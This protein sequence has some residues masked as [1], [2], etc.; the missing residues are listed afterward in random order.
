MDITVQNNYQ[1]LVKEIGQTFLEGR[2]RAAAA[3]N[4]QLVQSYW[5]IGK[6]IVEYE[7]KGNVRAEYG[8]DLIA[9]LS[10]DLTRLYGKG[11]GHSNLIYIRKFYLAFPKSGTVSHFLSWSH[12]YEILKSDDSLEISFYT[13]QCELEHWS[14][15]ELK[16]QRNSM[17]FQRI[18]LSH[19]KKNVLELAHNGLDV[20]TPD[21]IFKDQY[22][23]EFAGLPQL[24][25][26][27]E[28]DLEVALIKHLETFLLELGK[29]FAFVGRQY[30]FT[31][32]GRNYFVDLV[33]YHRILKCFVLIDLKRGE[34][35]HEDIGQM[36]FYL[37]Y[38][39]NE[40]N[41]D[42]DNEPIGIVLGADKDDLMVQYATQNISN[43]LFVSKYQLYL[44]NKEQLQKELYRLLNSGD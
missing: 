29:G 13:K 32:G 11:F 36:N 4:S 39:R 15:R 12:Y 1:Q 9:R 41:T 20:Q 25:T 5:Q 17:L 6:Y 26:Y 23:L 43:Q 40:E 30:R 28:G 14:V 10:K 27:K 8:S 19:D 38:F 42:G 22:I 18:A 44:P 35:Q 33:F 31:V 24:K 16:R 2:S 37:N 34:I 21:D 7:Q 3:I